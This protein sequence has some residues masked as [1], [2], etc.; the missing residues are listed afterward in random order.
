VDNGPENRQ[1]VTCAD[2]YEHERPAADTT[3]LTLDEQTQLI[4]HVTVPWL[5]A[6]KRRICDAMP[7]WLVRAMMLDYVRA[8]RTDYAPLKILLGICTTARPD[9]CVVRQ[10]DRLPAV[11]SPKHSPF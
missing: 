2:A 4:R 6:D 11:R 5:G 9:M 1:E 7:M 10:M 8:P 3:V